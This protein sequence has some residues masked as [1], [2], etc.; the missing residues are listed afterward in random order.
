MKHQQLLLLLYKVV[1]IYSL[2]T[3]FLGFNIVYYL[4]MQN[5][6]T[7]SIF[8]IF[9]ENFRSWVAIFQ[10]RPPTQSFQQFLNFQPRQPFEK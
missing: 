5:V 8:I 4:Q 1:T 2:W 6:P 3:R 9:T 7:G 10:P